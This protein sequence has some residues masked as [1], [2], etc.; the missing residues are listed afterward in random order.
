MYVSVHLSAA[1][2]VRIQYTSTD[3]A[4][5][6][7]MDICVYVYISY[8]YSAYIYSHRNLES[9]A[10]AQELWESD[11]RVRRSTKEYYVRRHP[12]L[13]LPSSLAEIDDRDL[14]VGLETPATGFEG[15]RKHRKSRDITS[16]DE[17]R[18]LGYQIDSSDE[19]D[20]KDLVSNLLLLGAAGPGLDDSRSPSNAMKKKKKK[21]KKTKQQNYLTA[22]P[23]QRGADG[24]FLPAA[25]P[26]AY[27]G[28]AAA[29]P[30]GRSD[31]GQV[32]DRAEV[33]D[34]L[35]STDDVGHAPIPSVTS[36]PTLQLA[37]LLSQRV[38]HLVEENARLKA[39][40]IQLEKKYKQAQ[41]DYLKLMQ[42]RS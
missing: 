31:F 34:V 27:T 30:V 29:S 15:K 20:D 38:G 17:F 3:P 13:E 39:R 21:K 12:D 10:E 35:R 4:V 32:N 19:D 18:A 25:A 42:D 5:L 26:T 8:I 23:L 37:S 7:V 11:S 40:N 22:P 24:R 1:A 9:L 14:Y 16:K 2:Y 33:E 6:L 36:H 41:D 28:Q